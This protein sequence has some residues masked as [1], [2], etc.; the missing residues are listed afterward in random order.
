MYICQFH[1]CGPHFCGAEE[2]QKKPN[3]IPSVRATE[4]GQAQH[5]NRGLR[6][7]IVRMHVCLSRAGAYRDAPFNARR[8]NMRPLRASRSL[9]ETCPSTDHETCSL[10]LL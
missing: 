10:P 6:P 3:R 9:P 2:I 7:G 8:R 1:G 5:G 4:Q